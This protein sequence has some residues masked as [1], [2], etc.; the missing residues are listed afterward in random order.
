VADER[1][2]LGFHPKNPVNLP[3]EKGVQIELP[4]GLRGIG[5]YGERLTP[6]EAAVPSGLITA[7]VELARAASQTGTT[8]EAAPT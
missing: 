1:L 3:P 2:R 7:L 6:D 8:T 5:A 4:P